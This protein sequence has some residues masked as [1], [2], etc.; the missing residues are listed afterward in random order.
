MHRSGTSATTRVISLLGADIASDLIPPVRGE[1]DRG[2]WESTEVV[3]IHDEVLNSVGRSWDSPLAYPADWTETDAARRGQQRIGEEIA[4]NFA[5][6]RVF[7]VKDPRVARL[8]PLWLRAFAR[9]KLL[10]VDLAQGGDRRAVVP[11][12]PHLAFRPAIFVRLDRAENIGHREPGFVVQEIR[13]SRIP[14][15]DD[16]LPKHHRLDHAQTEPFARWSDT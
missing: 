15:P 10:L 1:N 6:S 7:V 5:N 3:R 8:L 4:K 9:T 2:F 14:G 13:T 12:G 11:L 16:D